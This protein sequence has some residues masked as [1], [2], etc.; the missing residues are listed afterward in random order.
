MLLAETNSADFPA[1]GED[2]LSHSRQLEG[3]IK[4]LIK[5]QGGAINF[6][7]FMEAALYEP[8]LGYYSAGATKLGK[9]GDFV[10]APEI[11]SLFSYCLAEQC[12]QVLEKIE[13]GS[14]LELGA[15]TGRMAGDILLRLAEL[16][17][18]P[19]EYLILET[20]ADLCQRQQIF[21]KQYLPQE[22]Y[23]RCHW[24][25]ELPDPSFVGVVL[26]NEV[27]DALPVERVKYE[28][29]K[30]HIQQVSYDDTGLV[31]KQQLANKELIEHV[32][33]SLS[34]YQL[35][36]PDGYTTEINT[37]LPGWINSLADI[38][39]NGLI[40][41]IDYGYPRY[42]YYHPQRLTGTLLCHYQHRAHSDPF[43]YVGLQDITASVDFTSVA[44]AA[45]KAGLS[46]RGY[47]SQ[48]HFLLSCGLDKLVQQYDDQDEETLLRLSG[49]VKQL[50]LPVEMGER[51]KAIALTRGIDEPLLG[52][53]MVD[54]RERL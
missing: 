54:H 9:A 2:A 33:A 19:K 44:E 18:L 28:Q 34:E 26:A 48:A 43:L 42:E 6:S 35:Q 22:I 7:A 46:V 45:S 30:Y 16:D 10:T 11:S 51:F 1:P 24:L 41:L 5:E 25:H 50:T 49:E 38:L 53:S 40:L 8:G 15:G 27:L 14:V 32:T 23:A 31:W 12:A 29:G 13:D 47:C 21:L 4:E 3:R 20:S 37:L 52:F 39:Q 36:L 17:S